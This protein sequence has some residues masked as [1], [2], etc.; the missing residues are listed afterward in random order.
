MCVAWAK[1]KVNEDEDDTKSIYLRSFCIGL[2]E[3][4]V[5]YKTLLIGLESKFLENKFFTYAMIQVELFKYF[6]L[7]PELWAIITKIQE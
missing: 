1:I 7:F 5:Q 3:I 2:N 6:S 4:L